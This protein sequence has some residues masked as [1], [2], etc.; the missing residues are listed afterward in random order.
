MLQI[1]EI[2]LSG[3]NVEDASVK[4]G[5][6]PNVV[7]GE[8]DTGKSYLLH[9]LDYIFGAEE[10]KKRIPQAE[11]Y[12]E[13]KVEFQ[14]TAGDYL[15]LVRSLSGGD[16]KAHRSQIDTIDG[17]GQ[18]IAFRRHGTS[19]ADDV[20][21]V[22]FSFADIKD[23]MLRKDNDGKVQRLTIRTFMPTIIVDEVS[24]IEE[25][26]PVLGRGGFDETARKRMFAYMLSGKDDSSV[27]ASEKKAII[28]ARLNAQV[29][30]ID[31]LLAPLEQ[32]LRATPAD[33]AEDSIEK[34]DETIA[35][36]SDE[37]SVIE[38]ERTT[39]L[40]ERDTASD[41]RTKA[42]TQILAIDQLLTRY[43][44]LSEHYTSDLSRLDFVAEGVHYFDGLQTVSCPLCGQNMDDEHTHKA[45][46][47]SADVYAAARAE[48]AKILAQRADLE[49]AIGSLEQRREA[50][51]AEMVKALV[52]YQGAERQLAS[53][54]QPAAANSTAQL[55][56]LNARRLE[57]ESARNTSEQVET[58][59]A[60]KAEI[61]QSNTAKGKV[62]KQWESLP[63]TSLVAFCKEVE[64][65][66]KEWKWEGEGRVE[67]DEKSFDIKVDGQPRQ[68]HGAGFR[69]VLYSAFVIALARYCQRHSLP[70]PG[71][72]VIDKPLT[73]YKRH[74]ARR[75]ENTDIQISSGVETAFWESL[76]KIAKDMQLIV[77]E[78]KEPPA[79]V[80][81]A[82]HYEW[83]A[84]NEAGPGDRVGFIPEALGS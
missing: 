43:H 76:T 24:V 38:T 5:P 19:K 69:A 36:V 14:S 11:S 10:L 83:F 42:Q 13:L 80:A 7:A 75:A 25:Q 70:H 58:L 44:L 82:I 49:D 72:V 1:R 23:A 64:A 20:T 50:R 46:Q 48:A 6:G 12:N 73:S 68:S 15:T 84:G 30:L 22:L 74:G 28:T 78:N 35:R 2:R 55:R 56:R 21:S 71:F 9:C 47:A 52:A 8:S 41:V 77:V 45:A 67:F 63:G 79:N 53:F 54:L 34:I 29:A 16:L 66:L 65:I 18:A 17:D 57:L 26:S 3:P 31:D 40:N 62:K 59:R 61:E 37:L 60:L 51:D 32:Q 81:A 4:F 33:Q 27:V 39:L